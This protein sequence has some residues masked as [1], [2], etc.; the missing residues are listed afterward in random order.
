MSDTDPFSSEPP[1]SSASE[2]TADASAPG[3]GSAGAAAGGASEWRTSLTEIFD[4]ADSALSAVLGGMPEKKD[5]EK[6]SA[7][8]GSGE[9]S[10]IT[11]W[12]RHSSG[13][14]AG[15]WAGFVTDKLDELAKVICTTAA[16]ALSTLPRGEYPRGAR[17]SEQLRLALETTG[18]IIDGNE[19]LDP[20]FATA[21][22]T[23]SNIM[24]LVYQDPTLPDTEALKDSLETT[25]T[26]LRDF[27]A[28]WGRDTHVPQPMSAGIGMSSEDVAK[29][30]ESEAVDR[31]K[32]GETAALESRA[33]KAVQQRIEQ[34]EDQ[35]KEEAGRKRI[36][37]IN[38]RMKEQ[39]RA[40][41]KGEEAE[42]V[43]RAVAAATVAEQ[44]RQ[45]AL[46]IG[47]G[48]SLSDDE[49]SEDEASS[50]EEI[51]TEYSDEF[52]SDGEP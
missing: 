18:A 35:I 14:T 37:E 10:E 21:L 52:D 1:S 34:L 41:A 33:L 5:W 32:A 13:R 22:A 30:Y 6:W 39:R 27:I 16:V 47:M 11:R 2:S 29:W 8:P 50:A 12:E 43:R 19:G 48:C 26:K 25:A 40:M 4:E 17:I 28:Q 9:Q 44:K 46:R 38:S 45:R 51:A 23:R 3:A 7:M 49:L 42:A 15:I 36:A 24:S 20:R 31:K